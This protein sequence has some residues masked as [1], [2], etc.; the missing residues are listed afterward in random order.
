VQM[1]LKQNRGFP[2]QQC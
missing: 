2:D 1:L